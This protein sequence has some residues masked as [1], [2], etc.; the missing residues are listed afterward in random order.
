MSSSSSIILRNGKSLIPSSSDTSV[1]VSSSERVSMMENNSE[2]SDERVESG[3]NSPI[4][5]LGS[6]RVNDERFDHLPKEM[7]ALKAMMEKLLEQNDERT[8]HMDASA[9]TSSYAVRSSNMV[10]GVNRTHSNQRNNFH[11][12]E[13]EEDYEAIQRR[14]HYSTPSKTCSEN[15]RKQTRNYFRRMY[16]ISAELKTSTVNPNICYLTTS[17]QTPTKLEKKIKSTSSKA[18]SVTK[19]STF[20]KQSQ[21]ASPPHC[22]MSSNY[23]GKSLQ[24]KTC[25]K[26][27]A[28]NGTRP[29]TTRP[30]R[31]SEI[32]LKISRKSPSKPMATKL[33]KV[34]RCSSSGNYPSKSNKS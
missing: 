25:E 19:P 24:R 13:D 11:G 3:R 21:L 29:N 30:L 34:S 14:P 9:T 20:G 2:N 7:S 18:Y 32:S 1:K 4:N 22:K 33:T 28:T 5:E 10:T 27:R 6:Q 8:R 26:L 15:Y 31:H 17:N 23:S 16:Q 12:E